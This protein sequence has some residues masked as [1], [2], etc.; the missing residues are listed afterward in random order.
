MSNFRKRPKGQYIHESNWEELYILTKHWKSDLQFY[1]ED[2]RFLRTLIGKYIIWIT[3]KEH[4]DMVRITEIELVK[5]KNC[6]QDLLQKV[7]SHLKQLATMVEE[8]NKD[9]SRLFRIEHEHLEDEIAEFVK[10]FRNNR[11]ETFQITEYIL[12]VEKISSVLHA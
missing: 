5:M 8:G 7:N 11:K 4:L 10:A 12:D 9:E 2:L 6:Y 3:Q 1:K